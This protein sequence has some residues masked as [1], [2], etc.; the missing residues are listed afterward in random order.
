MQ[1]SKLVIPTSLPYWKGRVSGEKVPQMHSIQVNQ[2][3]RL[4]VGLRRRLLKVRP[5]YFIYRFYLREDEE[6]SRLNELILKLELG[7]EEDL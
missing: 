7:G 2:R 4:N 5:S 3:L 6:L 1:S